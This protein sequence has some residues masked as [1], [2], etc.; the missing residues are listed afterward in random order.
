MH[1][2]GTGAARTPSPAVQPIATGVP[3][4]LRVSAA[5][6]WQ[7]SSHGH[8]GRRSAQRVTK[9]K[10]PGAT[11]AATVPEALVAA[12]TSRPRWS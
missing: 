4:R 2:P 12:A 11:G 6:A 8:A 9:V 1:P 10:P 7:F 5:T 3:S